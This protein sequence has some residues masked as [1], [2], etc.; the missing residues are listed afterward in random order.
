[1]QRLAALQN[2]GLVGALLA[3]IA[4]AGLTEGPVMDASGRWQS[5]HMATAMLPVKRA[6]GSKTSYSTV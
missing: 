1:M 5:L 4:P 6:V 2:T 3:T